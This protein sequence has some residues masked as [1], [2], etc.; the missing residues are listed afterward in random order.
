MENGIKVE[1]KD[2]ECLYIQIKMYIQG[3]GIMEE[4]MDKEHMFLMLQE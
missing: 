4:N 1:N 2:K 3:N